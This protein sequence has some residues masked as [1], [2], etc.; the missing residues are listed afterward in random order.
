MGNLCS[1]TYIIP[2]KSDETETM[3][4]LQNKSTITGFKSHGNFECFAFKNQTRNLEKPFFLGFCIV[5][6]S[7]LRMYKT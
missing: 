4:N 5:D 1:R 7:E 2:E 6:F 3:Q